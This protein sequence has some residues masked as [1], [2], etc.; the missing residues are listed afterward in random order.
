MYILKEPRKGKLGDQYY[1]PFP[2]IEKL[3]NHNVKLAIS[4]NK[5]R[6]VHED[7]LKISRDPHH[8]ANPPPLEDKS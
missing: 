6:I 8:A 4:R 1:G 7:K 3:N 5:V 2:I